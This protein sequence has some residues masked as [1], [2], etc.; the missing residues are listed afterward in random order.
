MIY[1][2][3][4]IIIQLQ[5]KPIIQQKQIMHDLIIADTNRNNDHNSNNKNNSMTVNNNDNTL[6]TNMPKR[7]WLCQRKPCNYIGR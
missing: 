4:Q 6:V 3:R 1:P 7:A 5:Q 2:K